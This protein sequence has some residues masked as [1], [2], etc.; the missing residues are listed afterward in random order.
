M[1]ECRASRFL[2]L[3]L[4]LSLLGSVLGTPAAAAAQEEPR[5][6]ACQEEVHRAFDYWAGDWRVRN[7]AGEEVGRNQVAVISGGCGLLEQ[8]TAADGTTGKSLNFVDPALGRWRQVWV[9]EGGQILDLSG[10]PVDG[11]MTLEGDREGPRGPVRD[12]IRWIPRSEGVVEQLWEM[13]RDGGETW[14]TAFQ[15]FYEPVSTG[16]APGVPR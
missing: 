10:D 15:G 5:P 11:V 7:P 13:S 6:P 1:A 2:P 3:F 4:P 12:R 14:S 8:W 16:D 9:G